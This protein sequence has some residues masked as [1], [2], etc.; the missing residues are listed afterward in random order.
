[1][2]SFWIERG[3]SLFLA[4][5]QSIQMSMLSGI[6]WLCQDAGL[7]HLSVHTIFIGSLIRRKRRFS[8]LV[9]L[10]QIWIFVALL[11]F[12][13][14]WDLSTYLQTIINIDVLILFNLLLINFTCISRHTFFESDLWFG[15]GT[16]QMPLSNFINFFSAIKTSTNNIFILTV[17]LLWVTVVDCQVALVSIINTLFYFNHLANFGSVNSSCD[18]FRFLYIY[19]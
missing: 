6:I 11:H 18:F 19:W 17:V 2:W 3:L 7:Y 1:M 10:G 8:V 13:T 14:V 12:H 4:L 16:R 9:S 15:Y 5:R